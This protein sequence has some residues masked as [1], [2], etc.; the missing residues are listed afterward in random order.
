M[1]GSPRGRRPA[2]SHRRPSVEDRGQHHALF[3]RLHRRW[4][5]YLRRVHDLRLPFD[6]NPAEQA[7][8]MGKLRI[9]VSECPRTLQGAQDFAAI[10][11]YLATAARQ[12]QPMLDVLVQAVRGSPWM[13]ATT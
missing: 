5:D 9:K 12:D 2:G 4:E 1:D 6:N 13:P 11:T 7:I 10:R 3:K 8:R